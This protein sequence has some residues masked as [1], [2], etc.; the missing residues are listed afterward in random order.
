MEFD[1]KSKRI[2]GQGDDLDYDFG[3]DES[4]GWISCPDDMEIPF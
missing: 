2:Y 4:G 1:E 3:W